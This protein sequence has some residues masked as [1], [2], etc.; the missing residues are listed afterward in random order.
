[1]KLLRGTITADRK[2]EQ[3][4]VEAGFKILAR[5]YCPHIAPQVIDFKVEG[6]QEALSRIDKY[7]VGGSGL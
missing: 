3:V 2:Y 7:W 6:S 4:I 5:E 1:M